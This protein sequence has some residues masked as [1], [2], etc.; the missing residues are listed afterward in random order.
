MYKIF[1]TAEFDKR[2]KK[3]DKQ[4]QK[5]I[6]KEIGK[7]E[8]DPYS[9]KPLGYKFFQRKENNELSLLLSCL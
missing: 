1:T 2:F 9:G 7:L 4:L 8:N 5:E 3:L 6:E